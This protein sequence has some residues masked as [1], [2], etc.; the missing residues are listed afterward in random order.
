MLRAMGMVPSDMFVVPE[1]QEPA[2]APEVNI[3]ALDI[4]V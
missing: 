1:G 2:R 4:Q 3:P